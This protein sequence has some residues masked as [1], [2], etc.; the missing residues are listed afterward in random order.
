M[1]TMKRLLTWT[2]QALLGA[3]IIAL[4]C[5]MFIEWMAGCGESYVDA[6]GATHTNECVF[7][8]KYQDIPKP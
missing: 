8:N 2:A 5:V 3:A 4:F 7:I 6:A 1:K